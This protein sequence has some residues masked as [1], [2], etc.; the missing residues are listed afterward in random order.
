[1]VH[2]TMGRCCRFLNI[3]VDVRR[4]SQKSDIFEPQQCKIHLDGRQKQPARTEWGNI[5]GSQEEQ[6]E[7]Q[8]ESWKY[9]GGADRN[10]VQKAE[11]PGMN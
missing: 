7:T 9:N 5:F 2:S 3:T 1:M 10:A 6:K 11:T 8:N 4:S